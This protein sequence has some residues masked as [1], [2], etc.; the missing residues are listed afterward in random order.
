MFFFKVVIGL[1]VGALV[2]LSGIGGGVLL[3]PIFIFGLGVP[4]IVAIGSD[5]AFNA[6]TKIGAGLLHW[7]QGTVDWRLVGGLSL[8][9][10]PGALGGV[11]LL[12]A[13][14]AVYGNGI[15]DVLR[16]LLGVVL[17]CVPVLL[18]AE[19]ALEKRYR[20]RE[21]AH[22]SLRR[23]VLIGLFSG[24]LVGVSS[25]GS[26]SVIAVLLLL[27]V[28]AAPAILVGTNIVH[29]IA[30][31]GF[32]SVL[33][34]RLGIIDPWLVFPLLLGSIPGSVLGVK[35]S[36]RLP[37]RWLRRG[38]CVILVASGAKMLWV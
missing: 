11:L 37:D 29:A 8:G 33:D 31:T 1:V 21:H 26:G 36:R 17:V 4:A 32:A 24:L 28:P 5:T 13:L 30:L 35:W 19:G 10:L 6:L 27:F 9:S 2:G 16:A 22:W 3:V 34:A 23:L 38:L 20:F 12:S 7:R 18:V 14:R 15:N 25:V